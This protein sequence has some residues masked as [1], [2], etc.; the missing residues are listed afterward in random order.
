MFRGTSW[1]VPAFLSTACTLRAP[2]GP[3]PDE[4]STWEESKD[5]TTTAQA[6]DDERAE[7]ELP[8]FD[9]PWSEL[10]IGPLLLEVAQA[11]E[12]A[13]PAPEPEASAA[14][15]ATPPPESAPPEVA[16]GQSPALGAE[17]PVP[18][19]ELVA[20]AATPDGAP[21]GTSAA[22]GAAPVEQGAGNG[23]AAAPPAPDTA[24]A[25]TD[26]GTEVAA[27]E[28]AQA[29]APGFSDTELQNAQ[30]F[31]EADAPLGTLQ[32]LILDPRDGD[33]VG[34]VL[35]PPEPDAK[36]RFLSTRDLLRRT[37]GGGL[38]LSASGAA[39]VDVAELFAAEDIVPIRGE[40]TSLERKGP[41]GSALLKVRDAENLLHR[42]RVAAPDLVLAQLPGF[43]VGSEIEA[44]GAATRDAEG[45]VWIA[46]NLKLGN[47]AVQIRDASGALL[48]KELSAKMLPARDLL[49]KE[50]F[51]G[52]AK[53]AIA[54]WT[55]SADGAH[56]ATFT[57]RA[58][59]GALVPVAWAEVSL[60]G[61]PR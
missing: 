22:P 47:Q 25:A 53:H 12:T 29:P 57:L 39:T 14:P 21:A 11:E 59:G 54:G 45:K 23:T 2:P 55:L 32:N 40:V 60:T 1:L 9:E 4:W 38:V 52:Q 56:V 19:P 36:R 49:G 37:A 43:T 58:E 13:P 3:W 10:P 5:V 17:V 31:S 51:H 26:P 33:V 6:V 8:E 15:E 16:A 42:I 18:A 46:A 34:A 44:E 50:V 48:W 24:P 27:S 41:E 61:E 28:Q 20:E 30:I 7:P 35:L